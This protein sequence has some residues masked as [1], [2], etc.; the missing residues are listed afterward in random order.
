[1][2]EYIYIQQ[3][4]D[5]DYEKKYKFGYTSNPLQRIKNSHEQHSHK[6]KYIALYVINKTDKYSLH[7][8]EYDK[9]IYQS[10][11]KLLKSKYNNDF[12]NL[13]NINKY[14]VNNGGSRE[15]IFQD[16]LDIF[17]KILLEE[18][19]ILGLNV[20]NIDIEKINTEISL[21]YKNIR[22]IHN[23]DI[24]DIED[25]TDI[26][27]IVD[28]YEYNR[29]AINKINIVGVNKL[30][31][32][33]EYIIIKMGEE[34]I[35]NN[36]CYLVLPTGGGKTIIVYNLFNMLKPKIILIFSPRFIINKQNI[37]NKYLNILN[38][39]YKLATDISDNITEPTIIVSC[40][41]SLNKICEN[42]KKYQIKDI[43]VWFDE[44]HWSLENWIYNND[45]ENNRCFILNDN[46]H[47]SNRIFSSASP[48]MNCITEH[49]KIF[50]NI[51]SNIT[52]SEL[53][54]ENY[55]SN[56]KPYIFNTDKNSPDILQYYLKG[57]KEHNKKYGFSFHHS[58]E[59]AKS[60]FKLHYK[61]Y[62]EKKTNIKP[63]LLISQNFKD[64][65]IILEYTYEN[66]NT[67]ENTEYSIAYVVD[68]YSMG[69]D[70]EKIDIVYMSDPKRSYKDIIQSIGR[71]MR[72]DKK[73]E[74]GKNLNKIL[75]CY[76]PVYIEAFNKESDYKNIVDVLRYL[77]YN[78]GLS[79]SDI[80]FINK[81][82]DTRDNAKDCGGYS[83][84][85]K[86]DGCEDI[87]AIL[88]ELLKQDHSDKWNTN[89]ITKHLN[90]YNI[91][92]KID[93]D[94]YRCDNEHLDLPS[95]DSLF[96]DLKDFS[97]YNTYSKESCPYYNRQECINVIKEIN[98]KNYHIL[99]D[100]YDDEEKIKYINNIDNKIPNTNLWRFY[101]GAI[102]DFAISY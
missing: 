15:F 21:F 24:T 100:M 13:Q 17:N 95:I 34:L 4:N 48:N 86:Y 18:F 90:K 38:I 43:V 32:Y 61:F 74:D 23:D 33:Q 10:H 72:P 56:I 99:C 83:V 19:P 80:K 31:P 26:A 50:G 69:Y 57:F 2:L 27:E 1:M 93:Y 89:K 12:P 49:N 11:L 88:L 94:K 97:W 67:F 65:S 82:V 58:Q 9:I 102:T 42:I 44:A 96:K 59:N 14:I 53:I 3:N 54:N 41:Q 45:I 35:K 40:I 51:I 78:I 29:D 77:I 64:D 71:G 76:M 46:I 66:V 36:R 25:T 5:W 62:K 91:H 8:T 85:K 73:G 52:C 63:F 30:R 81:S 60:L 98:D 55:L 37:S 101:G 68:Q 70:F 20:K 75:H 7:Y 28:T 22:Q 87:S 47:I 79:F 16:G 6:S 39:K 84:V 92:S